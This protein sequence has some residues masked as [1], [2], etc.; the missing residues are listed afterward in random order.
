MSDEMNRNRLVHIFA[1]IS[2]SKFFRLTEKDN[3][4]VLQVP[5]HASTLS[6]LPILNN[7]HLTAG[8]FPTFSNPS[9]SHSGLPFFTEMR[10][11]LSFELREFIVSVT[12]RSGPPAPYPSAV[13][14]PDQQ[15]NLWNGYPHE[16]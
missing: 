8:S 16:I 11:C 4:Q 1:E 9:R 12:R 13:L 7:F 14:V 15:G 2:S 10:N 3:P 6:I 5:L